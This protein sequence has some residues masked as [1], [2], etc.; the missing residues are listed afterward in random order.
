MGVLKY[1]ELLH[2]NTKEVVLREPLAEPELSVQGRPI[3]SDAKRIT[4]AEYDVDTKDAITA[5]H[6]KDY[7]RKRFN[8]AL[9][10]KV[11]ILFD[12]ILEGSAYWNELLHNESTYT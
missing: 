7:R 3:V 2:S 9:L 6:M 8:L 5:H 4:L 11:D 12:R 1:Y 10:P